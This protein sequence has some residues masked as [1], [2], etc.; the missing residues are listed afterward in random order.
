MPSRTFIATEEKSMPGFNSFQRISQPLL[1]ADVTGDFKLK[2]MFIYH[3]KSP[4]ALKNRGKSI[5][6]VLYKCNKSG[7]WHTCLK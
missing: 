5:L 1:A 4:R 7:L 3:P 2:P 6:L